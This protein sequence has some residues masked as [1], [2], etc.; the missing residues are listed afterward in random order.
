MVESYFFPRIY[1]YPFG[2]VFCEAAYETLVLNA[3]S[4][5][6]FMLFNGMD[7]ALWGFTIHG[8]REWSSFFYLPNIT[9]RVWGYIFIMNG[10]SMAMFVFLVLLCIVNTSCLILPPVQ[11]VVYSWNNSSNDKRASWSGPSLWWTWLFFSGFFWVFLFIIGIQISYNVLQYVFL[12][13]FWWYL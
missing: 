9:F 10:K 13:S 6:V 1:S 11:S 12:L 3:S 5:Y 8:I 2:L 4:P 7:Q